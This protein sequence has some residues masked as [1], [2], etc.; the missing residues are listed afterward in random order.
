MQTGD[1]ADRLAAVGVGVSVGFSALS[2]NK[3]PSKCPAV[4]DGF[5]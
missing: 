5:I 2:L 4:M 1:R 3:R